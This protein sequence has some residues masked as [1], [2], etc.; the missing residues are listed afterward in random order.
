MAHP[1]YN[2]S[3]LLAL[4]VF[5]TL[6]GCGPGNEAHN[7]GIGREYSFA[8]FILTNA[9]G[10]TFSLNDDELRSLES[11]WSNTQIVDEINICNT[12]GRTGIQL[13][14]EYVL[15]DGFVMNFDAS[16]GTVNGRAF[17]NVELLGNG[18]GFPGDV[19]WKLV[20]IDSVFSNER[21]EELESTLANE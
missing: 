3:L 7:S 11:V 4:L 15:D 12:L 5:C 6:C 16:Y 8:K 10:T 1:Y 13:K 17:L 20:P 9:A 2:S 18:C 19:Y 21:T 14:Y